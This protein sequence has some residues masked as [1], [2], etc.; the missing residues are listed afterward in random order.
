MN[1]AHASVIGREGAKTR[2]RRPADGHQARKWVRDEQRAAWRRQQQRT[3]YPRPPT[4]DTPI[5]EAIALVP[6]LHPTDGARVVEELVA[7]GGNVSAAVFAAPAIMAVCGSTKETTLAALA[8]HI[9]SCTAEGVVASTWALTVA[10]CARTFPRELLVAQVRL[11]AAASTLANHATAD[12]L[13]LMDANP[14]LQFTL[15]KRLG[16]V[17]TYFARAEQVVAQCM[18]APCNEADAAAALL[19]GRSAVGDEYRRRNM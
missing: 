18:N 11:G 5:E 4:R 7:A 13:A 19:A 14:T 8:A 6:R 16:A 15:A 17:D 10:S 2:E 12:D 3:G 9:A 1:H